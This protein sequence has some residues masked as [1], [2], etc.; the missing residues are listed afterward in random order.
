MRDTILITH[1]NPEDN[2][3]ARWLAA[4]LTI[5]GYKTWVDVSSLRGGDDFWDRIEHVL[6]HEAVKQIVI[7]SEHVRKQGVKKELALGDAMRRKLG[8]EAFIIPIRIADV[9]YGCPS[10]EHLAQVAA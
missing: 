3:F 7:V 6:R 4:R 2:R 8:D 9:D 5:A 1:A 10:S